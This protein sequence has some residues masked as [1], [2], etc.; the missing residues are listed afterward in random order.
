MAAERRAGKERAV[1]AKIRVHIEVIANFPAWSKDVLRPIF[2]EAF[3][4]ENYVI[5]LHGT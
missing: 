3:A 4:S 2:E 5:C 1:S